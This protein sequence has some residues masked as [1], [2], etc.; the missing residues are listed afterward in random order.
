MENHKNDSKF[1]EGIDFAAAEINYYLMEEASMYYKKYN[2]T[3]NKE[4]LHKGSVLEQARQAIKTKYKR[5]F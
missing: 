1:N 4:F 3:K 2:A 5:E